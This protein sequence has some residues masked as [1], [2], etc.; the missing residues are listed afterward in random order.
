MEEG[1][2]IL[3]AEDDDGHAELIMDILS[4]SGV[5]NPIRR[6]EEG[7]SLWDFIAGEGRARGKPYLILL[8]IRMPGLSGI[9]LLQKIKDDPG[10]KVIPVIMLTTTDN[11][12]EI[13]ECYRLGCNAYVTKPVDFAEFSRTLARLG[14]F[15]QIS[16]V[17]SAV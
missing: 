3:L 13:E 1:I 14:L 9:E 17:A 6:F 2:T 8:D 15:L 7:A 11:P 16:R 10:L 5:S 12:Q 4:E